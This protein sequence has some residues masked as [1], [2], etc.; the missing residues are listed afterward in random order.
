M[1]ARARAARPG[2]RRALAAVAL[3]ALAPFAA[4]CRRRR[5]TPEDRIREAIAA[6]E[7]AVEEDDLD[8]VRALVS[9][10]YEDAQG[11]DRAAVLALLRARRLAGRRVHLTVRVAA[12]EV[13]AEDRARVEAVVGMASAPGDEAAGGAGLDAGVYRFELALGTDERDAWRIRS[14]TWRP[15]RLG[16]RAGE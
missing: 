5:R 6:L 10:R 16:E 14:A 4:A 7:A 1:T 13:M 8:A 2:R 9:E 3:A 15:A 11:N 12:I